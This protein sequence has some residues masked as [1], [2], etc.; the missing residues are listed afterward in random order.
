MEWISV[1]D[2]LPVIKENK[3]SDSCL[4]SDGKSISLGFL[5]HWGEDDLMFDL[6]I[7]G[8]AGWWDQ[9]QL[10]TEESPS[11]FANVTHWIKIPDKPKK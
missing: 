10:L 5:E 2:E 9:A 4:I 1:L 7:G 11:G 3:Y 6:H 8:E